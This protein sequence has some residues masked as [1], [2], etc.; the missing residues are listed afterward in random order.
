MVCCGL[1]EGGLSSD[2]STDAVG[3]YQELE[4]YRKISAVCRG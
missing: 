1:K 4:G 3:L 2:G